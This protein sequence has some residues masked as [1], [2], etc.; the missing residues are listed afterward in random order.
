MN[1]RVYEPELGRFVS[2]DPL[3]PG[4]SMSQAFNRYSYVLNAP[5]ALTDPSGFDP[6]GDVGA[7][8]VNNAVSVYVGTALMISSAAQPAS[9]VAAIGAGGVMLASGNPAGVIPVVWGAGRSAR[10]AATFTIGAGYVIDGLS[11]LYQNSQGEL[12][13]ATPSESVAAASNLWSFV[14]ALIIPGSRDEAD[15]IWKAIQAAL[16]I[17]NEAA[18]AQRGDHW[19]QSDGD[20]ESGNNAGNATSGASGGPTSQNTGGIA[21]P[22]PVTYVYGSGIWDR[23]V[24]EITVIMPDGTPKKITCVNGVCIEGT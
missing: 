16:G 3:V 12:A 23:S 8:A 22:I 4:P 1:G 6:A 19:A 2:A 20:G 9:G 24:T 15:F 11:G 13:G 7:Q 17:A 21:S 5:L 18:S 14:M 10:P